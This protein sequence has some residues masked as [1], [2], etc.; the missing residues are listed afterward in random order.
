[1]LASSTPSFSNFTDMSNAFFSSSRA[2]RVRSPVD[3]VPASTG[4]PA[5][6]TNASYDYMNLAGS[7]QGNGGKGRVAYLNV[8]VGFQV[9]CHYQGRRIG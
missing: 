7:Q 5:S 8:V 2:S 3:V 9:S 6:L 1:M 4:S